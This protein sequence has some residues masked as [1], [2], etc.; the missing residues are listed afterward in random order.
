VAGAARRAPPPGRSPAR[1][2][3]GNAGGRVL[4]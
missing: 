4:E 3:T 2:M 1:R